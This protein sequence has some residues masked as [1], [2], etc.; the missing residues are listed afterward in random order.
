MITGTIRPPFRD[1]PQQ[2]TE[3]IKK[4]LAQTQQ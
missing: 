1:N 3:E 4:I 2:N